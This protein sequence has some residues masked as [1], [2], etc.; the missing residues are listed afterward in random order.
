LQFKTVDGSAA[1]S[2]KKRGFGFQDAAAF[3]VE[4]RSRRGILNFDGALIEPE[5]HA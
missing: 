3:H 5:L 2:G 4:P 1:A